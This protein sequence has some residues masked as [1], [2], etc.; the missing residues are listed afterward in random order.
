MSP[1]LFC[2]YHIQLTDVA[3]KEGLHA[4]PHPKVFLGDLVK[5]MDLF[6]PPQDLPVGDDDDDDDDSPPL[7]LLHNAEAYKTFLLHFGGCGMRQTQW[8]KTCTNTAF[9]QTVSPTMESFLVTCYVNVW[10]S[11]A[12]SMSA[13]ETDR[14]N[15]H[16]LHLFTAE[17]RGQALRGGWN[18]EGTDLYKN[19]CALLREQ[20]ADQD[21]NHLF[22]Q[23]MMNLYEQQH[24]NRGNQI[25]VN[26]NDVE[27]IGLFSDLT[28][29][30]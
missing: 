26:E 21:I 30:A 10:S 27:D 11:A 3:R 29:D 7:L 20:R 19:V 24:C 22:D 25:P 14:N 13:G 12:A 16:P 6:D 1:V 23:A 17:A 15:S 5:D 2:L 8:R 28:F 18:K 9:S 4:L